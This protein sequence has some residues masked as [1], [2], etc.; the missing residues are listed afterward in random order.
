ASQPRASS[1]H[2]L[3][4]ALVPVVP[5]ESRAGAAVIRIDPAKLDRD[6]LG[7]AE[8]VVIDHPGRIN[9][10]SANLLA[11]LMRR[12]KSVLYIAAEPID[13]SNLKL[14][15]DA[16]GSDLKLPV[17]FVPPA[18]GQPR[19]D[20]FLIEV[21][22]NEPPF[23]ALGERL[24]AA[25]QPLRFGGGLNSRRTSAGLID[26][27]LASYSDRSAAIVVSACGAGHLAVLNT[28]LNASNLPASPIFV[29]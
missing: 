6:S 18:S 8:L 4:R 7:A 5:R 13:A 26:D 12:G 9:S 14:I 17:E 29:P 15:S 10:A 3:E 28:E 11:A 25:I 2:F 23:A 21:R 24:N 20:L 1:S 16:A 19:R 22:K 27:V